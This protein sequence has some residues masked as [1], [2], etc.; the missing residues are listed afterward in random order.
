MKVISVF[1]NL[2]SLYM[3][4]FYAIAAFLPFTPPPS[5]FSYL[6]VPPPARFAKAGRFP[7][8]CQQ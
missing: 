6:P 3:P 4:L 1:E 8:A 7:K 2:A 5:F